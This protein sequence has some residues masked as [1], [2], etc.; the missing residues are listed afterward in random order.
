MYSR[1]EKP[2]K[3][4]KGDTRRQDREVRKLRGELQRES[5]KF[6]TM[7]AKYQKELE[8]VSSVSL[9]YCNVCV[10]SLGNTFSELALEAMPLLYS[11]HFWVVC[12]RLAENILQLYTV[13]PLN[14]CACA[15]RDSC[16]G[17]EAAQAM[18]VGL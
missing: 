7:V 12:S 6:S 1:S 14:K 17:K 10:L 9:A 5:E 4:G 11:L 16:G 2:G 8:D 13:K 15:F 3:P 18:D